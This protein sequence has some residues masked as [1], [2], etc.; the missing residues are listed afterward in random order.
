M[1]AHTYL[2][3]HSYAAPLEAALVPGIEASCIC[4]NQ[5][6]VENLA[7][8]LRARGEPEL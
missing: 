3:T 2:R 7:H 4:F 1:R 5:A 6:V 8:D